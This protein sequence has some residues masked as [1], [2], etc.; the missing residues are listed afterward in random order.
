M[1]RLRWPDSTHSVSEKPGTIQMWRTL[2][3][4]IN[5]SN[6]SRYHTEDSLVATECWSTKRQT[7]PQRGL[8]QADPSH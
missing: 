2:A 1:S 3:P 6:A 5:P 4:R 7:K 8:R